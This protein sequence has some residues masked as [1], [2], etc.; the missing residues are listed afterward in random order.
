MAGIFLSYRRTNGA[1]ACRVR[2]WLVRRLGADAVF[3]DVENIPF[4]VSFPDYIKKEIANSKV[5]LALIGDDWATRINQ[6]NDQVLPEIEQA[7]SNQ[8]PV[9]P[10]LIG[11]TA[12]PNPDKLPS[13]IANIARQNAERVGILNDFDA[14]MRLLLPKIEAILGALAT[15]SI[16][17]SNPEVIRQACDGITRFLF[18]T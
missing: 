11:N 5:M 10:V 14:H 17:T 9:L 8:I 12:M 13:S 18:E 4:A 7:L 6:P 16:V 3:M 2:E 15:D 1:Q